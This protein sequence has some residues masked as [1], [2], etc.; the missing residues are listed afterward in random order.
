MKMALMM[1]MGSCLE[2][3][4]RTEA[5]TAESSLEVWMM[6]VIDSLKAFQGGTTHLK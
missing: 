3:T 2:M 6:M 5:L 1:T 4:I